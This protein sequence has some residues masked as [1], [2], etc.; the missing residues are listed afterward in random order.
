MKRLRDP[1]PRSVILASFFLAALALALA[2]EAQLTTADLEGRVIGED[3]AALAGARVSARNLEAG[4]VRTAESDARGRYRIPALAPGSYELT[5][6]LTEYA[7]QTRRG[8]RLELGNVDTVDFELVQLAVAASDTIVVTDRAPIVERTESDIGIVVLQDE[9]SRLPLNSRNVIELALLSPGVNAFR[10]TSPPFSPLNFGAQNNRAT[11]LLIDGVD[12]SNDLLGGILGTTPGIV[13]Q[14]AT[15]QFEVITNRFKAEYGTS[16]AG[17]VNLITRPGT[18]DF[19]LD[20]FAFFRDDQL[21]ARGHFETEKPP[22]ERNQ[23]G[24]SFGGPVVRDRT[25]FFTAY[26]RNRTDDFV[27]V[28][29][30]GAFPAEEGTFKKPDRTTR[31]LFRLD[32]AISDRQWLE[33]R[34]S[35]L[36]NERDEFFGGRVAHSGAV[37]VTEKVGSGTLAH[38]MVGSPRLVNE[39]RAGWVDW[40]LATRPFDGGPRLIFP[41]AELGRWPGGRQELGVERWQVRDDALYQG[42]GSAGE[43]DWKLGLEYS[44]IAT[45]QR[46]DIVGTGLLVFPFDGAP[47]P[48]LAVLG[49]GEPDAGRISNDRFGLYVQNDWSPSPRWTLNLGV[50]Y[51][52]DTDAANQDF[53]S[54]KSDPDLPFIV[55][56]DRDADDDN[57]S[58]RTGF[59]WDVAGNGKTIVR[60]GYGNFYGRIL[61]TLAFAERASDHYR[62]YNVFFPGTSDPGA[63]DLEGLPYQVDALLPPSVE[64][65]Y[66]VQFSLGMSRQLAPTLALDVD[67]VGSRGYHETFARH[68]VN[69][70]DPATFTRRLPQYQ[71][72]YV[73]RDDGRSSYDALR[74]ALRRL[75]SGRYE[76]RASYTLSKAEN[77][78]DD[79]IFAGLGFGRGPAG[80]DER[81][82]LVVSGQTLLPYGI[83]LAGIARWASGRRFTVFTGNDENLNGDLTDDQPPGVG[84]NSEKT[85][86]F[87]SVDLRISREF[88]LGRFKL[89][90]VGEVFNLFDAVNF[91]PTSYI[92]NLN[93][94]SFGQPTA[95]L[96]PR[97]SQVGIRLLF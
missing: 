20:A 21:N 37:D 95:A 75:W 85:D 67:L 48:F 72:V 79:P 43:L 52:L 96:A 88:G 15:A 2:A 35:F 92:G 57:I 47:E 84:R 77:D 33:G 29:T 80:W 70:L 55:H 54:A 27:V 91:D 71:E 10:N 38:R 40:D 74:L 13:P 17:I 16:A 61:T 59:A 73:A 26:E 18:N 53:V 44:S 56:G 8:I 34:I 19:H 60:G 63:I 87:T 6:E 51:D 28:N 11:V 64:T 94:P 14:N 93:S 58:L 3:G 24:A 42:S 83:R 50:R 36:D 25:H 12:H 30:G 41:S 76:L 81:H 65:P 5:A 31:F 62:F 1:Y 23:I 89:E 82:H 78:F 46:A 90:L 97:Q 68:N 22:F 4:I 32:H 69:P 66:S 45:R 49:A 9:T 86:G 7:S 39:L